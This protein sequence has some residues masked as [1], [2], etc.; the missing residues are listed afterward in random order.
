VLLQSL[1]TGHAPERNAILGVAIVVAFYLLVGGRAYC[2]W[3]CPVNL[4][5]DAAAW[6]R[7]RLG[8]KGGAH[9]TRAAR[10]WILGMTLVL[11]LVTGTI[12][13]ELINPVLMEIFGQ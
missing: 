12:A 3:V 5:T 13:W 1:L 8:L 11:A 2:S 9:L 6:L 7:M 10:Y 4:L